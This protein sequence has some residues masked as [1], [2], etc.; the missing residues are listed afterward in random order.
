MKVLSIG[1]DRK[2]FEEGSAVLERQKEYA[3]ELEELHIVVFTTKG[4]QKK[5]FDNLFIYPT[6]SI[7]RIFYI[8]K[9]YKIAKNIIKDKDG[10]VVTTQ[11][12]FE[13]G[14]VGKKI[15]ETLGLPLQI[16]IHTDFL[17]PY[18]SKSFLNKIRVFMYKLTLPYADGIRVVSSVI[19]DSI[20]NKFP[21]LKVPV[22]ILPIFVD[23]QSILRKKEIFYKQEII[24]NSIFMV[25]RLTKEKRIDLGIE[26]FKK[27]LSV[28]NN[29]KLFIVGSGPE[30]EKIEAQIK[31]INIEKNVVFENWEHDVPNLL[32]QK[33]Q[34][35][36]LTSE[37]EGYGLT[38]IEAAAAGC[39]IVTTS[40]GVAKTDLFENGINSFVCPVGDVGCLSKSIIDL[41]TDEEKRQLFKERMQASIK[42]VAIGREEYIQK[43]VSLLENL[44][45]K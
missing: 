36:L 31:K 38:L 4:F 19:A 35:F 39:P 33:S 9:A 32:Y 18:F 16:Q 34:I 30:K 7:F 21:K 37:Y 43:Y 40:V 20:K 27:V 1:T 23:V 10:F 42:K 2:L 5:Q 24:P 12:P 25:S 41:I 15:K 6:N 11:D 17:D 45:R 29:A 14:L 8:S 28:N 13:T 26:V 22:D 44:V 3:S